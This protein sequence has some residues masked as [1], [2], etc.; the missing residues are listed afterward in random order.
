[1]IMLSRYQKSTH[2]RGRGNMTKK[3]RGEKYEKR[4]KKKKK[5]TEKRR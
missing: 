2:S 1:M 3:A 4:E 5:G